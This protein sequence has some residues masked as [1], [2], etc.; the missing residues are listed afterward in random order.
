[1]KRL[2]VALLL[3]CLVGGI[4]PAQDPID[5][6]NPAI[7]SESE[8]G[9][10]ITQ[11]GMAEDP[12]EKIKLLETFVSRYPDNAVIGY[13]YL[14]LQGFHLPQNNF[15]KVVEYGTKLLEI[16]P[17]DVEVRHNLTKGYE[18]KQDWDALL[19]HLLAT[20]PFSEKD[21]KTPEPEYE[22]EVEA[23]QAK[24]DYGKGV[25][26]YIE[27]SL[28]TSALKIT[29]PKKKTE[30]FAALREYYPE[31]QYAKQ[32]PDYLVQAYQQLGDIPKMLEEMA[33]SIETNPNNEGYLFTLADSASRQNEYDKS[34]A[35]AQQLL[36]V[37]A[38]KPMPDGQTEEAWA[39]HKEL[40]ATYGNFIL[41]KL[42]VLQAGDSKP[43]YREARKVLLTTVDTLTEQGGEIYGTLAYLLGV[44]YV[45]LDIGGDNINVA[46]KWMG[47]AAE[48]PNPYQQPATQTLAA[49]RKATE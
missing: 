15:D 49:I 29:D 32:A 46:K 43:E 28:Y 45:K 11:A 37:M 1:M 41:G 5:I 7:N 48:T 47:I 35:Y 6:R 10:L 24:I 2:A 20:K 18:G 33:K 27:Y 17:A 39:K 26:Q 19:P 44:C 34:Q 36:Q 13:V 25:I 38:E 23:W 21:T 3:L 4:V 30:Y 14:Q 16:V 8:Q 42:I 12:A 22:D 40:F 9:A 31:G